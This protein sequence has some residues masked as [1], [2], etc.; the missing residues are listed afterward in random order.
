MEHEV[1]TR[2]DLFGSGHVL[3]AYLKA[4]LVERWH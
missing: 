1:V 3:L 2:R 4:D